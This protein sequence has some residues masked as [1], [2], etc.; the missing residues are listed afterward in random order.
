MG[1]P[2]I[3]NYTKQDYQAETQN[4]AIQQTENGLLYFGNNLG[5]L[6][7]DGTRWTTYPLPN[8]SIVRSLAMTSEGTL[9]VGGQG[10]LGYFAE[11]QAGPPRYHSL[12]PFLPESEHAFAD[13]WKILPTPDGIFWGTYNGMF[14]MESS[15]ENPSFQMIRTAD[16]FDNFFLCQ[17]KVLVAETNQGIK[18]WENGSLELI[19]GGDFFKDKE[20]V[21]V[22]PHPFQGWLVLTRRQGIFHYQMDN[23]QPWAAALVPYFAESQIYCGEV[24]QNGE[25][26]K[27]LRHIKK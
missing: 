20:I 25:F 2:P 19:P 18:V 1:T 27:T 8:R 11:S 6:E 16:R 12:L 22:L 14:R 15:L 26:L 24:L 23:I 21:S 13:V 3:H 7:F 10:E 17:G 5:L 9:L 4:W